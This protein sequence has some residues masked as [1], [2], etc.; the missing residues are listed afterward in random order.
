MTVYRSLRHLKVPV[1][2]M[3]T[4]A[5]A[6]ASLQAHLPQAREES[7]TLLDEYQSATYGQTPADLEKAR[8]AAHVLRRK[9]RQARWQRPARRKTDPSN[10]AGN[11]PKE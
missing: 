6:A 7:A 4:P 1:S 10:G 5:E 8:R 9:T 2:G 11:A 3:L